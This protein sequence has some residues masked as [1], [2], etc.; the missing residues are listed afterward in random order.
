MA[1]A[2]R[3]IPGG[4]QAAGRLPIRNLL[5]ALGHPGGHPG[6]ETPP[7]GGRWVPGHPGYPRLPRHPGSPAPGFL[8][9]LCPGPGTCGTGGHAARHGSTSSCSCHTAP[10]HLSWP[11]PPVRSTKYTRAEEW[12]R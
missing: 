9:S 1:R 2:E 8:V 10:S 4:Q 11:R 12:P 6:R 3:P 5:D 7:R